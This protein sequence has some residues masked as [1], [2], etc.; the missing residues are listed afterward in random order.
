MLIKILFFI[1]AIFPGM[2]FAATESESGST[3]LTWLFSAGLGY[4]GNAYRAQRAPFVDYAARPIGLNPTIVPQKQSGFFVPYK[5]KVAAEKE[6]GQ[7]IRW[8]GSAAADGSFYPRDSL[9]NANQ[10]NVRLLGGS[11]FIMGRKEKL[12]DTLYV[13][14]LLRKHRQVYVDHASGANKTTSTGADI[15]NRYNYF[16]IGGEAKYK[17]KTGEIN[18]GLDGKYVAYDYEDP[19]AVSQLDNTY[20]SVGGNVH[21]PVAAKAK[22]NVFLR[23]AARNYSFRHAL[24]A[25]GVYSSINNP[26]RLYTYNKFGLKLRNRLSSE[27]VLYLDADQSRRAD[28]FVGYGDY[29]ENKYGIRLL[30]EQ[31]NFKSRVSV[32][33]WGRDYPNG[34]AFD[35][36]GQGPKT[37]SGNILKFKAELERG[38]N[39]SLWSEFD[40]KAQNTTDLRYDYARSQIIA[41]MSWEY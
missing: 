30:Y 38:K 22:L 15:S 26:L 2:A 28:A 11:E 8:L 40:Y 20:Y 24:D 5:M 12:E 18:Y 6:H 36:A 23:H 25:Q 16:A 35:V 3:D 34:F 17:H 1:A 29:T 33:H 31:G 37:Y 4:D 10:Y 14:A 13:G 21:V 9:S 39:S 7:D 27:W 19:I 32:H 41:G